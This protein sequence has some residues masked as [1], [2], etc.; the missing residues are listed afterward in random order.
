MIKKILATTTVAMVLVACGNDVNATKQ[1]LENIQKSAET[2]VAMSNNGVTTEMNSST[3]GV[4]Q[5]T[6]TSQTTS[7]TQAPALL[8][9]A[10]F[11]DVLRNPSNYLPDSSEYKYVVKQADTLYLLLSGTSA[12]D[13]G[14]SKIKV[15]AYDKSRQT[16]E[17]LDDE[18]MEG[19]AGAGGFRGG[20]NEY[21]DN[22]NRLMYV[23]M[24]TGSGEYN[25]TDVTFNHEDMDTEEIAEGKLPIDPSLAGRSRPIVWIPL[26]Q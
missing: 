4:T 19:T 14:L 8:T 1:A 12:M 16:V 10:V 7:T 25:V 23:T 20:L 11:N 18:F 2:T 13:R 17:L 22:P 5:A 15:F 3:M 9:P 21:T 24:S 6:T 26:G